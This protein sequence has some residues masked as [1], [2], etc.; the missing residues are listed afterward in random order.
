MP[1]ASQTLCALENERMKTKNVC[2]KRM[3][4]S[5]SLPNGKVFHEEL[6]TLLY[7][8]DLFTIV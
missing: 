4:M 7:V 2:K 1:A 8:R 5:K 3:H 6:V